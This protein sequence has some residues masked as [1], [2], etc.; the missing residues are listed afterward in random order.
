MSLEAEEFQSLLWWIAGVN[1]LR[2]HVAAP[3]GLVS[4]LVVVDCRRQPDVPQPVS[5]TDDVS[6]LVVVDCRRQH[7]RGAA[8]DRVAQVSILVVVDCR[9]Q[10]RAATEL[11]RRRS[12]FQSLLWWIAGVNKLD[13]AQSSDWNPVSILVVVDCRRQHLKGGFPVLHPYC[14]NP[15]CGGLQAS[16]CP[17]AAAVAEFYVFQSLLWWIAGVNNAVVPSSQ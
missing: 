3:T 14:F 1:E 7:H 6:I 4:I 15:C 16:T 2:Q 13:R 12:R 8:I 11:Y 5:R 10:R 17:F 9:R